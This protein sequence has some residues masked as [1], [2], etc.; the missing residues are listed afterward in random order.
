M[1]ILGIYDNGGKTFDRYTIVL[2]EKWDREGKFNTCL[3]MSEN[4]NSHLG[5]C[6][7]G[8][9]EIGRHLGKKLTINKLPKPCIDI[10]KEYNYDY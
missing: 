9:C 4:P 10:L 8:S 6:E 5:Y 1:K 2:D 7:H 3:R